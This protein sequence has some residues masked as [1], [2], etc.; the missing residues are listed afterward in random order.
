MS[1]WRTKGY[2]F[3]YTCNNEPY[4][5]ALESKIGFINHRA[6]LPMEHGWRHSQLHN[7]ETRRTYNSYTMQA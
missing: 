6:Y 2:H 4:L 7:G 5:E 3:C 1:R